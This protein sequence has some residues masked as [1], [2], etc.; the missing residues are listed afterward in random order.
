[1]NRKVGNIGLSAS[2]ESIYQT[3]RNRNSIRH[4]PHRSSRRNKENGSKRGSF[5][6][7]NASLGENSKKTGSNCTN[8]GTVGGGGGGANTSQQSANDKILKASQQANSQ[9][10]V[11]E[12]VRSNSKARMVSFNE[13]PIIVKVTTTDT[14]PHSP[15]VE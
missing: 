14:A 15:F 5:K 8:I 10:I 2:S 3:K 11:D 9:M 12:N 1:M 7:S 6:K 4:R 13:M